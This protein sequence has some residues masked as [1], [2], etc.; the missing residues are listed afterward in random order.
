MATVTALLGLPHLLRHREG[1]L[2]DLHWRAWKAQL[3]KFA[4][5]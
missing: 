1:A 2:L 5:C 4:D 3:E